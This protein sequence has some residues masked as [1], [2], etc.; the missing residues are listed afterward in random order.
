MSSCSNFSCSFKNSRKTSRRDNRDKKLICINL[1]P[2]MIFYISR[3]PLLNTINQHYL[4]PTK[5]C[6]M[7]RSWTP[8]RSLRLKFMTIAIKQI[9]FE[10]LIKHKNDNFLYK[11]D[12]IQYVLRHKLYLHYPNLKKSSTWKTGQM[13]FCA[14]KFYVSIVRYRI[15]KTQLITTKVRRDLGGMGNISFPKC[16]FNLISISMEKFIFFYPFFHFAIAFSKPCLETEH[17]KEMWKKV[18]ALSL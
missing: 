17:K 2:K 6:Q 12:T 4:I 9:H 13:S 8:K 14:N 11:T 3:T 1:F 15:H 7:F 18:K 5:S 16:T 10:K